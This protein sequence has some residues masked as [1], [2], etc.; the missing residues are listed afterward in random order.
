M[1]YITGITL[2]LI[3]I[4]TLCRACTLADEREGFWEYDFHFDL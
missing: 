2:F 3:F 4:W 1:L